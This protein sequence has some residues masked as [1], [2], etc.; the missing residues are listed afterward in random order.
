MAIMKELGMDLD[1]LMDNVQKFVLCGRVMLDAIE[2]I[3]VAAS[4]VS[5]RSPEASGELGHSAAAPL[6]SQIRDG[7]LCDEETKDAE[8]K[9]VQPVKTATL[10][11]V[12]AVMTEK[13]RI[14]YRAEV[15]ALLTAHGAAQKAQ[16]RVPSPT[17]PP[18]S[19]P[20][21]VAVLR[22]TMLTSPMGIRL[23]R[24]ARPTRSVSLGPQPREA[25]I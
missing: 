14:G 15:K 7:G 24:F 13:S 16:S 1:E 3:F 22:S 8:T 6:S 20:A 17:G 11:E 18:R 12:R 9:D 25:I 4:S 23:T 2:A 21:N 5:T 19:H 10:E